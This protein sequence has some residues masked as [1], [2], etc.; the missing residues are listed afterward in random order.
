MKVF[1]GL[2]KIP[3]FK[4]PVIA[5][6][7]FDGVH[8]GHSSILRDAA[9]QAHRIKG[10]SIVLTFDPHPQKEDSLTSV[11]HRLNLIAEQGI[12]VAIVV[13][14]NAHFQ[15]ISAFDFAKNIL[16]NKLGAEYIYVGENFRFGK[17]ALGTIQALKS[18]GEAF[19]FKVKVFKVLKTDHRLISSTYIRSLVRKGKLS[20]AQKLLDRP[21][22]VLGSVMK[23]V[24][25]GRKLGFPTANIDP[26]HEVIPPR[27]V[28]AVIVRLNSKRI[29]GLCNIG[30]RPTF[31]RKG[32]THIE[33]HLFNF[34]KLI[35]GKYLEIEFVKRIRDEKKFPSAALLIDQIRK[36][37]AHAGTVFAHH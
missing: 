28:Y 13:N 32:S 29:R 18:F 25:L 33:V 6:G 12:D 17:N 14:F 11:S 19:G 27:G 8:R 20:A 26:H 4:K 16:V 31:R 10:T 22:A 5:L 34:N 24:H 15:G 21:V 9:R 36:D 1:Y 2:E 35:Y 3:R 7:V 30:V 23:G 37:I